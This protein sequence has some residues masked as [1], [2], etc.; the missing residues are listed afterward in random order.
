MYELIQINESDYYVNCPAKI[1]IDKVFETILELCGEAVTLENL[2]K[3]VFDAYGMQANIQQFALIGST[4]RSYLT[5][6][7]EQGKVNFEFVDNT[8]YWKKNL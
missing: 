6:L 7:L 2:L 3:K 5:N 1:G 8:M 4:L